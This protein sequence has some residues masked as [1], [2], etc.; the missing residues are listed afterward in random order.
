ML[1]GQSVDQNFNM[2]NDE[3]IDNSEDQ[4]GDI[5][6]PNSSDNLT[7]TYLWGRYVIL[8]CIYVFQKMAAKND[9]EEKGEEVVNTYIE[10]KPPYAHR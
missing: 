8:L 9:E 10:T 6:L 4:S 3:S 7:K 2:C 5:S 1:I